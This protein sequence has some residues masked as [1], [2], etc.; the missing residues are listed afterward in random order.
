MNHAQGLGTLAGAGTSIGYNPSAQTINPVPEPSVLE[1]FLFRLNSVSELVSRVEGAI[2]RA[3]G[4]Q[5]GSENQAGVPMPSA[6]LSQIDIRI[7]D[8]TTRLLSAADR[9][10]RIA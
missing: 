10:E 4:F 8:L 6:L 1:G 2:N 7:A 9:L 5:D 3:Q